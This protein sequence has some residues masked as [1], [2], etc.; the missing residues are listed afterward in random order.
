MD[1][2]SPLHR[3]G[4]AKMMLASVN[5]TDNLDCHG[6]N[7]L[8]RTGTATYRTAFR[9]FLDSGKPPTVEGFAAY[10]HALRRTRSQPRSTRHWPQAARLFSG[11]AKP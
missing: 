6:L 2:G 4:G 8:Q 11:Q 9:A 10:I 1:L 5:K 3:F 7:R